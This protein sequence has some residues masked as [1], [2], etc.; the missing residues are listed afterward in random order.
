[1]KKAP[2][3]V[4]RMQLNEEFPIKKAT[5]LLPYLKKLGIEGIYCSPFFAA[6]SSH[7][8]DIIDPNRI[9]P[10]ISTPKEFE[11]F[12]KKMKELG[13]F[14]IADI[15]PNHMGILGGNPWWN[16]VLAKGKK[17]KYA[18]FFD[19]DWSHPKILIPILGESYD[20]A[21]RKKLLT[22]VKKEGKL[23]AKY[24]GQYFPIIKGK[25]LPK[26]IEET[27]RLLQKQQYQLADWL[28]AAQETSYRRFFNIGE[29]IGIRIENDA[30]FRAHHKLIF[31]LLK[32]KKVDGLRIDQIGR[33]HV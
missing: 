15:V 12:C 5:E 18:K 19:I 7:G 28:F 9:N 33:A 21:L 17:S 8:Y 25:T 20:E 22:V 4:Y 23:F 2:S 26:T 13:L 6:R 10:T 1:M 24:G 14:H 3:S 29:L 11:T 31:Q 32:E 27:D 30:L 16:D